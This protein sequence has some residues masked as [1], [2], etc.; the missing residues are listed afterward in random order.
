M[1]KSVNIVYVS[2]SL[3]AL[4]A[5]LGSRSSRARL[6]AATLWACRPGVA[7]R[8]VSERDAISL[9][10]LGGSRISYRRARFGKREMIAPWRIAFTHGEA[11]HLCCVMQ[12]RKR[13]LA[14]RSFGHVV[15]GALFGGFEGATASH[16]S[17]LMEVLERL[18]SGMLSRGCASA[19]YNF[20]AADLWACRPLIWHVPFSRNASCFRVF[21]RK[22]NFSPPRLWGTYAGSHLA[23]V[24]DPFRLPSRAV[25]SAPGLR[26]RP[27]ARAHS[28]S[29]PGALLRLWA[30]GP[31][32]RGGT[33]TGL[34]WAPAAHNARLACCFYLGLRIP[35]N[36]K[37]QL[38]KLTALLSP[39][40]GL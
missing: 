2:T 8:L 20:R 4:R 16:F 32:Q 1:L 17:R 7:W 5:F 37:Q 29:R 21:W 27:T 38:L 11:S 14:P 40:A 13:A 9:Y 30:C 22:L 28:F 24:L 36:E 15:H 33:L 19:H 6:A 31:L 26:P 25:R 34:D 10:A 23:G 35:R 3:L 12:S 39:E 18:H